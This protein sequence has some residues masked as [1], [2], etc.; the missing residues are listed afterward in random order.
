[1][2]EEVYQGW[3]KKDPVIK[4]SESMTK[5]DKNNIFARIIRG[6]IDAKKIYEDDKTLAFHDAFPAAPTHVLVVPKGEYIDF[7]EFVEK[8]P[9]EEIVNFFK[10]V[11]N[12]AKDLGIE[13]G[14]R[15]ITNNGPNASQSIPHFHMHILGG[16]PL[17]GLLPGDALKR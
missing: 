9:P 12:I 17:G 5:Y 6:E 1:M 2:I 13:K 14:Y 8:A 15:A 11:S 3:M 4:W 7:D 10:T 16:R